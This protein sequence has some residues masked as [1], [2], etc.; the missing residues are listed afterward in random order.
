MKRLYW[1]DTTELM[2]CTPD[3]F[4]V[5][6]SQYMLSAYRTAKINQYQT[7][8]D[9]ARCLGAGVL[10]REALREYLKDTPAFSSETN[11]AKLCE[12]TTNQETNRPY[13]V[14]YPGFHYS[15]SHSGKYVIC[16]VSDMPIGA[17]IQEY[18]EI[19]VSVIDRVLCADEKEIYERIPSA[20]EKQRTF[21]EI[22]S[23]H[24]S[25]V[26]MTGEGMKG[27]RTVCYQMDCNTICSL[28]GERLAYI[29]VL[30]FLVDYAICI[31]DRHGIKID[32]I[33]HIYL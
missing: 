23:A 26:K 5:K 3:V 24:E 19:S 17:D 21:F 33:I 4:E 30:N 18:K 9:R 27:L 28:T 25:Y 12:E 31:C 15:I 11:W 16:A 22:W 6:L 8:A 13:L 1:C 7:M 2:E 32:N 14:A 10:L 29:E 20:A